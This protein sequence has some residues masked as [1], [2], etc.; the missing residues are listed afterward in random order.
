[1]RMTRVLATLIAVT[2]LVV[3]V[4]APSGTASAASVSSSTVVQSRDVKTSL[5]G[6]NAGNMMSDAVFTAS[7]SM[8]EG[9]IQA[10]FN[11]KV[12][13]CLGGSDQYGPIVC[14]KDYRI[15]SVDRPADRYCNGYTGAPNETAATIIYRVAQSCGINPQVLIVMLQKEQSLVTH[16]WPSGNRYSAALGQGCPDAGVACDPKYVG[17]FHQIYGA[18]RQMQIYMEGRYFTYYAP[19][20]TWNIYWQAPSLVNGVWSYPCGSGPVY[21]AN[22]ATAALYYYT[23]Y[24]PNAAA[25]AAGY[26]MGDGCSAYG[27]RNFY[28]YFTDWFGS[29][30]MPSVP[31]L[32]SVSTS[33][34][35]ATIDS[36]G[37]LWGYP[38]A[39]GLWGDRKQLAIGVGATSTLIVP[40]DLNGDGSKDMLFRQGSKVMLLPG[41][42][43][44]FA[45]GR[46]LDLDWSATALSTAAGDFDGDGVPD[47]LTTNLSGDLLLWRGDDRGGLLPG[48]RVGWGWGG[49]D[50]LVGNVDLSGDGNADLIARDGAGRLWI[51]YGSGKGG[52]VGQAQLGQGW[53]G[54]T[55]IFAPGD[56]TGDGVQDIAARTA[57]GDLYLYPGN[58]AGGITSAGRIGNG[59]HGMSSMAG[60]GD[61]VTSVRALP[62]GAG[63]VDRDNAPDVLALSGQGL[64][65]LYRGNAAGSWRGSQQ[66]GNGWASDDRLVTLGDFNGDGVKDVGRI[67][68]GGDFMLFPGLAGGGYG[69]AVRIG[70]GWQTV[71]LAVGGIDF[72][73]DRATDIIGR[74]SAGRLVLYRG[75]GRGGFASGPTVIGNGWNGFDIALHAGDFDGD[76]RADMIARAA[77]GS[78]WL[79]P[80]TG[81]GSWGNGRQIGYG[82]AGFTSIVGTGDFDGNGTPDVIT[83]SAAGD[84]LLF[85]GDGRGGWINSVGIGQGW[86]GFVAL[87]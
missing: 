17:F 32:S 82:W 24:Q 43:A 39:K 11:S 58:G 76:G 18:A 6:F 51:Y 62:A 33:S 64:L 37:T 3:G 84:L 31:I 22:K 59:W 53:S 19:G 50:A 81:T 5:V 40:G 4:I 66:I 87:G 7:N 20:R 44:S 56:F 73:G 78:L 52:F 23:P 60:V 16:T 86:G 45:N 48:V 10:F 15:T 70:Q 75:D 41:D 83:R 34:Y 42:G 49:F 55:S 46:S 47:V 9:Q 21:V 74:D 57:S 8:T 35:V 30:Q 68:A 71:G 69:S 26:G 63:D 61:P 25:L 36:A 1:M 54:M 14:L 2:A 67:T 38:F 77:D 29:T 27:N 72:D 85:R 80:T 13:R 65:T 79:Y 28:N 12:S